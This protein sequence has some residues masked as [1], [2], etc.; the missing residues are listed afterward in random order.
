MRRR[1]LV[2]SQAYFDGMEKRRSGSLLLSLQILLLL[3]VACSQVKTLPPPALGPGELLV[4]VELELG[5]QPVSLCV[6]D[7]CIEF[8]A[9]EDPGKVVHNGT[10]RTGD[11]VEIVVVDTDGHEA[12]YSRHY[13]DTPPRCTTVFIAASGTHSYEDV[14]DTVSD[15]ETSAP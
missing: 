1:S 10:F 9:G 15:S 3:T 11:E 4:T 12:Q 14:C 8:N 2:S 13:A 6:A 7:S 5:V